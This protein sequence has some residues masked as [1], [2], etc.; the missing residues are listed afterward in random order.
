MDLATVRLMLFG[1]LPPEAFDITIE[2]T[3]CQEE[4]EAEP[5]GVEGTGGELM[6]QENYTSGHQC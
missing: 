5:E 1:G 2:I 3:A 6:A 4:T